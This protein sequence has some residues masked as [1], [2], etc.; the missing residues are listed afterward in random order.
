MK[1]TRWV[2]L[3]AWVGACLCGSRLSLAAPAGDVVAAAQV[4]KADADWN[5][6]AHDAGVDAWMAFYAD[7]AIVL[8]PRDRLASG[9]PLVRESVSRLLA[10]PGV[11]FDWHPLK[12]KV[13]ASG[14]LAYALDAYELSF[15]GA[16]GAPVVI[17]GSVVEIWRKQADGAWKCIVDTWNAGRQ[18]AAVRAPAAALAPAPAPAAAVPAAAPAPTPAPFVHMVLSKYGDE[19]VHYAEAIRQYFQ[20]HLTDP[21]SVQLRTLSKPAQGSLTSVGGGLLMSEKRR[22]GWIVEATINARN[23]RGRYVGFKRYTFLFRGEKIIDAHLPL[24]NGEMN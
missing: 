7:D 5:A 13:S 3:M 16:Q 17:R 21:G 12:L 14:D 19:P 11:S 10:R 24:P 2:F 6:A 22:Y 20:E 8:L 9:R 18:G 1:N 15:V 23:A 4:R